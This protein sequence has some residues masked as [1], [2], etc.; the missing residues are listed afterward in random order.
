MIVKNCEIWQMDWNT[1]ISLIITARQ[2]RQ[3]STKKKSIIH[4][5]L[6][7]NGNIKTTINDQTKYEG[8]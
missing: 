1:G 2:Q 3:P 4:L 6:K 7:T 5:Y 8:K